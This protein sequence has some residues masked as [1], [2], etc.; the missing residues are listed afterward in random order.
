MLYYNRTDVSRVI[1]VNKKTSSK[2]CYLPVLV[3]LHIW[4]KFESSACNHLIQI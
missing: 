3:F 1:D 2:V 4:F